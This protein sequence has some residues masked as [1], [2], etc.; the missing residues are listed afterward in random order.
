VAQV[1]VSQKAFVKALLNA[2]TLEDVERILKTAETLFGPLSWRAV[3]DRE[4]NIGTIRVGSDP[5]LGVVERV[6]NGMDALLDLGHLQDPDFAASSPREAAQL[7]CGVPAGGVGDMTETDR[8]ALGEKLRVWLDESGDPKR[9]TVVVED[10]GIGQSPA[11]FPRT[12]LSLNE[13]NKMR[14]T[15]NM[16]TYGQGGAVTYGFSGATI[17]ISRRHPDFL[18]GD[19]DRVGWTIVREHETDPALQILPS[20][21]YVVSGDDE[22]MDLDPDLLPDLGH[23]TRVIHISYDLQGWT[24]PFTTGLWQFFH[25]ALFDPVL[26]FL[27]TGK[28]EKEKNYGSRI[29]IGNA[30]RLDSPEKA[31]GEVDVAYDDSI[32]LDLGERF[33]HVI[34]NYWVV[35]RP[36]G[37]AASGDAAASYVRADSAIS[38]TLFGQRQDTESRIW[39]KEHAMLPFLFKN[40]VVQINADGLTPSAKREIFASTRERATKSDL[41]DEI[42]G[43]LASVLR[44]DEELKRLNH[45]EKER[46]LQRSTSASSEKVRKRLAKFIKTRLKNVM[47]PGKGG[48]E[49]GVGGRRKTRS[50]N[51]GAHR[52]ITDDNLP[53]VPTKL[54]FKRKSIR[55]NQGASGYTW[56]KIDAKNGYLPAH[57]DGLT[58]GWDGDGPG[59]KVKLKM[60]SKLLGG[61]SRWVFEAEGDA[62]PGDYTFRASLL[63]PNGELTD[64]TTITVAVPSPAKPRD[65]GT[66]PETGP[67]VEWVYREHWDDH[68]GNLDGRT[69]GYVTEDEEE[70]I[71]WVNRNFHRLDTAL[72]GRNLTAEQIDARATRYQFP[73]ACALWLQDDDLKTANPR[74]DEKYTKAEMDRLAEAVIIA[75]D[76]DVDAALEESDS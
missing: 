52:D 45:E 35:R 32:Q 29:I 60:R 50:G 41:R 64:T 12:L 58:L 38:M 59:D 62:V 57:D 26:P 56:V 11:N 25:S 65:K 33:G 34:F 30:A 22:V 5:A 55:V 75:A 3:G 46:L 21:K 14:Q 51:G 8:R 27:I 43:Q 48:F 74:P 54:E 10:D 23:G 63:T 66:E 53:R 49:P 69:V 42:Y 4:N 37:S 17:I 20:Y 13:T 70:T 39:I 40:M 16:G 44:S 76:P 9:P 73:V 36:E 19:D 24:G 2:R 71:I 15:W 68:D 47:K 6:T 18:D 7:W 61:L 67:R 31:R 28:R 1:E 72:S